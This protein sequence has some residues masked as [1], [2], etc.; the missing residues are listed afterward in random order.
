MNVIVAPSIVGLAVQVPSPCKCG[1]RLASIAADHV[2]K[3]ECGAR[4]GLLSSRTADF[5]KQIVGTFGTPNHP[6]I[7]RRRP[8]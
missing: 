3:C 7:L 6:I 4:R 2:L 1:S 8:E 5:L